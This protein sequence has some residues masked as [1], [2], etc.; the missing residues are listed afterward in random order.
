MELYEAILGPKLEGWVEE[1]RQNYSARLFQRA[2]E[3]LNTGD[4]Y[5]ENSEI[6]LPDDLMN[7][8][9]DMK[10]LVLRSP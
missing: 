7:S 8:L 2:Y 6:P 1:G 9:V 4:A 3:M 5:F 10:I